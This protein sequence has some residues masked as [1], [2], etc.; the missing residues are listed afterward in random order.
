MYIC[1]F[2]V[3][4]NRPDLAENLQVGL[5]ANRYTDGQGSP[6]RVRIDYVRFL[7]VQTVNDCTPDLAD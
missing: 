4:A 3:S 6:V 5:V 1:L 7:K 2:L